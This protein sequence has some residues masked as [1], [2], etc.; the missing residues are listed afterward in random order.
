MKL[1]RKRPKFAKPLPEIF[2][3]NRRW[4]KLISHEA[5]V[6]IHKNSRKCFKLLIFED[7]YDMDDF[8]RLALACDNKCDVHTKGVF[9]RLLTTD[10]KCDQNYVG[11]IALV[12]KHIDL[13]LVAHECVH[14]AIAYAE[15]SNYKW[16]AP[17]HDHPEEPVAYP[18]GRL[19]Q[20][21]W[22][23]LNEENLIPTKQ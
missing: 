6:K 16:T 9:N 23:Y 2:S 1:E 15:R 13:E 7:W 19:T 10:D 11:I 4:G 20:T 17:E 3:K 8:F 12:H 22:N 18:A 5:R 21:I 14:A